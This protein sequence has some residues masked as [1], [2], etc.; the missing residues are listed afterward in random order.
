MLVD[1][2]AYAIGIDGADHLLL[3]CAA[4]DQYA[5]QTQ[6]AHQ[7]RHQRQLAGNTGENTDDRDMP[8]DARGH[9]RLLQCCRAAHFDHVVDAT[10]VGELTHRL[11]PGRRAAIVDQIIGSHLA[12][13]LKLGIAGRGGNDRGTC[14]LGKLQGEDG[15]AAGALD[16]H[17]VAGL[18]LAVS[19]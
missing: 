4:A 18:Q 7:R 2:R 13:A 3:L 1:D 8:A 9:H 15:N 16:Q 19:H 14:H 12:Q 10:A 17:T 11:A 6:L 5:L